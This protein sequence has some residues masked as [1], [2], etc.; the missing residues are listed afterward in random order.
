MICGDGAAVY[1]LAAVAYAPLCSVPPF[2]PLPKLVVCVSRA[3]H[4]ND[5]RSTAFQ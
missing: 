4:R 1:G 2:A 5:I 3:G